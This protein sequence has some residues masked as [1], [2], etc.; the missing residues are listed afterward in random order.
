MY[1]RTVLAV[2]MAVACAEAAEKQGGARPLQPVAASRN[3]I[4]PST[5]SSAV[6][7][8]RGDGTG[9]YPDAN[10]PT[11]WYQKENGESK[12]I[13]WKTKLP[14]YSWATPVIVGD[15]VFVRS[16]PYDLICLNKKTGKFLWVR[17]HP[18][19]IAVTDE[20]K[21][22]NPE[23]KEI[24]SLLAELQKVNDSFVTQGWQKHL[25]QKK[26]DL[27]KKINDLSSKA[28]PK[29]K[30]PPDLYVESWA[31][32]TG[33][34]PCSD[35]HDIYLTSGD[36][37]T[38][39]YDLDG[40]RKW[41]R[42]E[43]MASVWGEHG[44]ACSPTLA[45]DKFVVSTTRMMALDKAT[46]AVAWQQPGG[47]GGY[48]IISFNAGGADFAIIG[49][50]Y[51]RVSDGKVVIQ[52][53]GDMP[54]GMTVINDHAVYFGGGRAS[55]YRWEA[56]GDGGLSITP[57]IQE[58]YNRVT[59]PGGDNPALKVDPTIGGFVT[60]SPL[61][62]DGLLYSLG[63]FGK[64]VVVDT[65]KTRQKDAIV[66]DTFPPFDF[67]NPY[68]RKSSGMGIG[69]S[70]ALAGKY[71][72]MLDSANCMIVMEPG[73]EYKQVAKNT[74]DYTVPEGWEPKHWMGAHH[75]QTEASPVFN[76]NHI[77]IRGEQYLYCIGEK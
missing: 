26:Y 39:C 73:R 74:I 33:A 56:K 24:E 72:F 65:R 67:R 9:R 41:A 5:T 75:E 53:V 57:L 36:G 20:E 23:F 51:V 29:Y 27:Q 46:G 71:I 63:N 19:C 13:L 43:S 68:S 38:A 48:S 44:Q 42:Y 54:G 11:V 1:H 35:G 15:K 2:L 12:N 59:L 60:A 47:V 16:E 28:D 25:Y 8:W 37:I 77:Y 52:R 18:P 40:K 4:G 62:H 49:G 10:P 17:S 7:G 3:R 6:T 32:Y 66:Y 14:C 58:E 34:T 45:G 31:G 76:G 30:L 21:K 50:N 61:Y 22:A 70:P 69:A 55:F 64:L